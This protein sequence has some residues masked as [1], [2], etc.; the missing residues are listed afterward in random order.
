MNTAPVYSYTLVATGRLAASLNDVRSKRLA[1]IGTIVTFA[2]ML[3]LFS[4]LLIDA[5]NDN[6][7]FTITDTFTLNIFPLLSSLLVGWTLV[8]TIYAIPWRWVA[9]YVALVYILFGLLFSAFVPSATS[10][11]VG[12]EHLTYRKDLG[13]FVY[14]SI[15]AARF[16]SLTPIISALLIDLFYRRAQR[17]KWSQRRLTIY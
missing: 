10:Y 14:L 8:A 17:K 4:Y 1:Y 11:L 5:T 16:W 13:I 2:T 6:G 9:S 7:Y 15:V 3:S 12:F